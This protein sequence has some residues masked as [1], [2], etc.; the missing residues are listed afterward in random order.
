MY[1][2][3]LGAIFPIHPRAKFVLLVFFAE[4]FFRA[5]LQLLQQAKKSQTNKQTK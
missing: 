4:L 5:L 2:L 3:H 1:I